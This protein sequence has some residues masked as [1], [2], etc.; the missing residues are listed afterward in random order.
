VDHA[1]F[2]VEIG[3]REDRHHA[4]HRARG[5]G[6]DAADGGVGVRA[7]YEGEMERAGEL[8]V[9]HVGIAAG[10][11]LGILDALD[12]APHVLN[13]HEGLLDGG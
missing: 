10:D 8:E 9:V 3:A 2:G 13:G 7:A 1:D 5:R 6:V 12:R 4:G 11:E